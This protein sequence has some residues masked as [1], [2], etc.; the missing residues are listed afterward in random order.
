[1][2]VNML[3]PSVKG[4]KHIK[5][6]A[7]FILLELGLLGVDDELNY[8]CSNFAGCR[9]DAVVGTAVPS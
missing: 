8:N 7:K 1:M 3:S 5:I 4:M 9:G 2:A 6:I